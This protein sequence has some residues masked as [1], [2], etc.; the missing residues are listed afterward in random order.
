VFWFSLIYTQLAGRGLRVGFSLSRRAARLRYTRRFKEGLR[1]DRNMLS[2]NY[3]L[4]KRQLGWLLL[5]GGVLAMVVMAVSEWMNPD[6]F[7]FVQKMGLVSGCLSVGI[8]LT[9][10]PLGSRP[11]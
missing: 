11:A 2:L 4:S 8:G 7:G 5:A 9:L 3:T 1:M 6:G 10:L